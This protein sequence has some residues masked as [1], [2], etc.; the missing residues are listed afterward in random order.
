MDIESID[1]DTG[2]GKED[3]RCNSYGS[4]SID[5]ILRQRDVHRYDTATPQ[6]FSMLDGGQVV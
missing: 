6:V 5:L 1:D 2:D 4:K 3:R